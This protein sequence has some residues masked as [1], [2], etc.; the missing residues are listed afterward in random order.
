MFEGG[1]CWVVVLTRV[2]NCV[3][4]EGGKVMVGKRLG[5]FACLEKSGE[6]RL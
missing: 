1:G 4:A 2:L 3:S 5:E 6:R